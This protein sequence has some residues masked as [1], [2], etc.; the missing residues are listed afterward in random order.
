MEHLKLNATHAAD[1]NVF[2]AYAHIR[3]QNHT[4]GFM[5]IVQSIE[6]RVHD[7]ECICVPILQNLSFKKREVVWGGKKARV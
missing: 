4:H 2:S 6:Y 7:V 3:T 1:W 5:Y